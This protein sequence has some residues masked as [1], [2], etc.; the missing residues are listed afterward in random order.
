MTLTEW[1]ARLH[2]HFQQLRSDRTREVGNE[3]VFALAHGLSEAE[4]GDLAM[5]L[6]QQVAE[7]DPSGGHWLAWVVYAAE[8]GYRYDGEE[9][10]QTFEHKTPGWR[11]SYRSIIRGWFI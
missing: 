6:R 2:A 10:W 7:D 11:N 1:Q 3:P 4:L 5:A 8:M 9:Y